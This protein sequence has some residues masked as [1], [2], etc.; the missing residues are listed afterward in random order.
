MGKGVQLNEKGE[1]MNE[2]MVIGSTVVGDGSIKTVNA[3]DLHEF[4]ESKQQFADWIK[5]RIKKYGFTEG[6][7]FVS[8]HRIMNGSQSTDYHLSLDMAKELAM[9]ER[10]DKGKEAR[11]YFIECERIALTPAV[12]IPTHAEALRLAAD[13]VDKNNALAKQIEADRPKV[14]FADSVSAS[15]DCILIRE[16]SKLLRQNGLQVGQ[17]RLF[18]MLREDGFL[19]KKRG[20]DW[21]SPTQKAMELGLFD[22]KE[23]TVNTADGVISLRRTTV[24]TGKGQLYFIEKYAPKSEIIPGKR[25]RILIPMAETVQ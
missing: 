21:N 12:H 2:I 1:E 10:N 11:Q 16:L 15:S 8:V 24:V 18:E 19:I 20:Q 23:S 4:L 9:V 5:N 3:R 7:D 6:M 17:N 14:V 25:R 22:V 13:L